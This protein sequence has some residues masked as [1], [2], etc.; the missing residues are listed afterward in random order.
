ME[1]KKETIEIANVGRGSVIGEEDALRGERH[2]TSCIC[3]LQP[4]DEEP[5][6]VMKISK[7]KLK[8][9]LRGQITDRE[10]DQ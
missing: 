7:E 3:Q 1:T 5:A 10:M 4:S 9:L 6:E 2:Q 8:W